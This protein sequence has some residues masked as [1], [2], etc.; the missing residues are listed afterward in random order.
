MR[1]TLHLP[2]RPLAVVLSFVCALVAFLLLRGAEPSLPGGGSAVAAAG[3][4]PSADTAGEIARLQ[5]AVRAAPRSAEPRVALA[6]AYLQRARETG[7]PGLYAR[8]DGLLAE[9]LSLRPGDPDALV[10]RAGLALSRHDFRDGLALARRAQAARPDALAAYPALVDAL[11]ELGRFGAAER[12][13]Q[14]ML[15]AKP[16]LAGYARVSYLRELHGDLD[17]AVAAMRRAAA[18]GGPARESVASVQA[19]L[20]GLELARERPA[21]ARRAYRAALAAVPAYPAAEAGLAR[22]AASTGDLDGAIRRWR[23]LSERLPLPEYVIGHGEAL[24][25][26]GDA[27][28]G[29][30]AARALRRAGR[31]EL[32]LVGAERRLSGGVNVDAELAI[33]EADHGDPARAVTLARRAWR[34]APGLRAT[35]A[36]GWA[37]TRAG[38][39]AAG[40]RWAQRALHLGSR[41]PVFRYHA[42]IAALAAGRAAEGRA[43]LRVALGGGLAGWPWQAAKARAALEGGRS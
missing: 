9:A 18:A 36:L 43:H 20:G 41:D 25:A 27:A 30:A 11:V 14:A 33:F 13:L 34:A 37:L 24:L 31:A 7:E 16:T 29:G 5:A 19:L 21:A 6:S 3:A 17:G 40:R 26:A 22:L 2:L 10:V 12:T 35:D 32:A 38:R 1:S 8:A 15:D 42:G 23:A 28:A 39:P 4:R